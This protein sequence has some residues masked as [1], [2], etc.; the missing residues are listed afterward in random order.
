M[1]VDDESRKAL[2]ATLKAVQERALKA[3]EKAEKIKQIADQS[4]AAIEFA[5]A[6]AATVKLLAERRRQR[7][8]EGKK[9]PLPPGLG[10][11]IISIVKQIIVSLNL[12]EKAIQKI[13]EELQDACPVDKKGKTGEERLQEL[14]T[15]KNK[16]KDALTQITTTLDSANQVGVTLNVVLGVVDTIITVLRNLPLPTAIPPAPGIPLSAISKY[17]DAINTADKFVDQ[18]KAIVDGLSGALGTVQ[19]IIQSLIEYLDLL[20][21]VISFCASKYAADN[22]ST[23]EEAQEIIAEFLNNI[24]SLNETSESDSSNPDAPTEDIQF[25]VEYNGFSINIEN[26]PLTDVLQN[27]PRRRAVATST[28]NPGVKIIGDYSFSSSAQVLIDTMKFAI[29]N[30]LG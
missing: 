10:G 29:D 9:P 16:T 3:A 22:A 14:I 25:P 26:A 30:Y 18:G 4:V 17:Y 5:K 6:A 23:A 12:Q 2:E 15:F 7:K 28:N 19:G 24:D 11:I 13:I 8:A 21:Q 27:I 1:A 20:D